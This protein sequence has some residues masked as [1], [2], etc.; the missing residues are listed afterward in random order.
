LFLSKKA[1]CLCKKLS[2]SGTNFTPVEIEEAMIRMRE[3]KEEEN[4]KR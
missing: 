3:K 1:T 2:S 4:G